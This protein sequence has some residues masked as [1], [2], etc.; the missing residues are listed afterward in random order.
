LGEDHSQRVSVMSAAGALFY[1]IAKSDPPK[2]EDF[3]SNEAK[4]LQPRGIELDQPELWS[5]ISVYNSERRARDRALRFPNLGGY[6]AA[7]RLP[8]DGPFAIKQTLGRGH[9][10]ICG[11]AEALLAMVVQVVPV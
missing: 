1:R 3:R 8:P 2:A 11:D 4:G 10:T 5:G 6:I 7:I 9:Y